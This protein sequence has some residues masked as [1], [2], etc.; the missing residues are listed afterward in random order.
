M[1]YAGLRQLGGLVA[2]AGLV[3]A[4]TAT[5]AAPVTVT[6]GG[7]LTTTV[8]YA[9]LDLTTDEGVKALYRR[10]R[11]A[12]ER[13]CRPLDSPVLS[14]RRPWRECY[15][16]AMTNAVTGI[17]NERL[18]TLHGGAKGLPRPERVSLATP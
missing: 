6:K 16:T 9:D 14:S 15:D 4:G 10:L 7:T 5:A 2:L 17:D 8:R 12:A 13:V 1:S 3:V 11:A 18:A